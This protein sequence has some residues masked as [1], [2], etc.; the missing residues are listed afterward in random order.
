[1]NGKTFR[2]YNCKD[3][4]LPPICRYVLQ[5]L[6]RDLADFTGFSPKFND[7]F[8]TSY[9]TLIAQVEELVSPKLETAER[10]KITGRITATMNALLDPVNFLARYLEMAEDSIALSAA[11]FGISD[12][13]R[14]INAPD[15]E[16]VIDRLK[17]V[18]HNVDRYKAQLT[19]QGF[20]EELN[21]KLNDALSTLLSDRQEQY[22]IQT[23]INA[24]VEGNLEQA[25]SLYAMMNTICRTGKT[26]YRV[27]DTYKLPEYTF[28]ELK[29]KVR[30]VSKPKENGTD[31]PADNAPVTPEPEN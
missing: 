1:M 26:L 12:L 14:G 17:N 28:S 31:Q 2:S 29:K 13:R 3:E 16:K 20:S 27:K 8:V 11:D 18:L 19:E 23:T 4:E 25:N 9:E 21:T 15:P 22:R 30:R 6:K 7:E 5:S 24:L 10:K